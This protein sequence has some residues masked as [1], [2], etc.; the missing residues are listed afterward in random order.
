[1][2]YML[3]EYFGGDN[4]KENY[5]KKN[6]EIIELFSKKD[7]ILLIIGAQ[8]KGNDYERWKQYPYYEN[9]KGNI[10]TVIFSEKADSIDY[11]KTDMYTINL[12]LNINNTFFYNKL[13]NKVDIIIF[14]RSTIKFF[15]NFQSK[16]RIFIDFG[17]K[18]CGYIIHDISE[19]ISSMKNT[20][21]Y[22]I[23]PSILEKD[24]FKFNPDDEEMV[25][26]LYNEILQ[27]NKKYIEKNFKNVEVQII[28][29]VYPY[30]DKG[31]YMHEK[32][33]Y[34]FIKKNIENEQCFEIPKQLENKKNLDSNIIN[35]IC[36]LLK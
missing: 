35:I 10:L 4:T 15:D 28:E 27:I 2:K 3:N 16:L 8:N 21:E 5:E 31:K 19:N 9:Y 6:K 34:L 29:G 26:K 7:R 23:Q 30:D 22:Y 1:M 20:L 25:N 24:F 18:N 17:L 14:D 12:D 33:K 32:K 11:T 36:D 13:K